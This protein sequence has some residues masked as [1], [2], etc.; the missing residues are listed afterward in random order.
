[1]PSMNLFGILIDILVALF[2]NFVLISFSYD[3][4]SLGNIDRAQNLLFYGRN[5]KGKLNC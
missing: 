2:F 5:E 4:K 1:M 3:V